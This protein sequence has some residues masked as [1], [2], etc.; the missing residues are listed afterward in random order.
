MMKNGRCE[1]V[2]LPP[3]RILWLFK[4][5][6]NANG[7]LISFKARLVAQGFSQAYGID[8][9]KTYAPITKLTAYCVIFALA[10]LEQ[11]EIHRMDIITAYL[12]GNL[13]EEIYM[14]HPEGFRMVM[15]RNLVCRLLQ[16]LYGLKHATRIWNQKMQ[17][18]LIKISL[19][20]SDADPAFTSSGIMICVHDLR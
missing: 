19:V 6:H 1:L 18:F 15:K 2:G 3:V 8:H 14:V 11:W 17:T 13:D 12:L 4:V 10:A 7:H 9:F 5:K 16:Y 20:R